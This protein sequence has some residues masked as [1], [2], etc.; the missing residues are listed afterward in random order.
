MGWGGLVGGLVSLSATILVVGIMEGII[1]RC[2][3]DFKGRSKLAS[4]LSLPHGYQTIPI[5]CGYYNLIWYPQPI[6]PAIANTILPCV[7]LDSDI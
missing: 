3:I 6:T 4:P 2:S 1:G 5:S 7:T